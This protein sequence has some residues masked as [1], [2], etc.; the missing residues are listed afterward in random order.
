MLAYLLRD[1]HLPWMGSTGKDN[2]KAADK[3]KK[4]KEIKEKTTFEDLFDVYSTEFVT[5]MNYARNMPFEAKP[6]Y[7]FLKELMIQVLEKNGYDKEVD[8]F[9]WLLK[10]EEL[11]L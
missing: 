1:G 10:R 6:D 7:E 3:Y 4:V 11:I 2:L 5:F 8:D 9:D